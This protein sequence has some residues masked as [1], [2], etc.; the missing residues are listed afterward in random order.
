MSAPDTGAHWKSTRGD[1]GLCT[2][3]ERHYDIIGNTTCVPF[4][5]GLTKSL[6]MSHTCYAVAWEARGLQKLSSVYSY[7]QMLTERSVCAA[8]LQK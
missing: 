4:P 8:A 5:W 1:C 2:V 6:C 3:S 7:G